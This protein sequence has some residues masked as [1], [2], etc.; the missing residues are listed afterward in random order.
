ME[1]VDDRLE[2]VGGGVCDVCLVGNEHK[3][4]V[5]AVLVVVDV[6]EREKV[7]KRRQLQAHLQ[8]R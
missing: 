3:E 5:E 7:K 1:T 8:A 2:S 4:G 6:K